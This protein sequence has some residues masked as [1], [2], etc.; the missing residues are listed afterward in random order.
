MPRNRRTRNFS[1]HPG[2]IIRLF[3]EVQ[4]HIYHDG[5]IQKLL[6]QIGRHTT[7]W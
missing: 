6:T 1:T 3:A 4:D 7:D 2:K 5:T